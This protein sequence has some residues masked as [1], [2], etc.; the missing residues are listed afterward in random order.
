MVSFVG[1]DTLALENAMS[2]APERQPAPADQAEQ[3][4]MCPLCG[5]KIEP[6]VDRRCEQCNAAPRTRMLGLALA[7][8]APRNKLNLPVVHIAPE[9]GI[10]PLMR[11]LFGEAPNPASVQTCDQ[12]GILGPVAHLIAS[13]QAIFYGYA[14][15]GLVSALRKRVGDLVFRNTICNPTRTKQK[16]AKILADQ[17]AD[18][19]KISDDIRGGLKKPMKYNG[20]LR[21]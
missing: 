20:P 12:V 15:L 11:C 1:R 18:L 10:A 21:L 16:E 8:A 4:A 14:A 7:R 19:R 5:A 2:T 6:P 13:F 3:T 9:R 17:T